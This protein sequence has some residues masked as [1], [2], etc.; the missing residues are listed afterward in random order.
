M[1]A[2]SKGES[3]KKVTLFSVDQ[4]VIEATARGVKKQGAKLTA[5]TFMFAFVDLVLAEKNGFYTVTAADIIEPFEEISM[6]ID[7]FELASSAL[8]IVKEI[9]RGNINNSEIF[10]ELLNFFRLICFEDVSLKFVWCKWVLDML[11][12]S[13]YKLDLSRCGVCNKKAEVSNSLFID[14]QTGSVYCDVHKPNNA[15]MRDITSAEH[16][17]IS[18]LY[19]VNIVDLVGRKIKDEN[20]K[21]DQIFD[22]VRALVEGILGKKLKSILE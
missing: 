10:I 20:I 13:G 17:I 5:C 11:A 12:L 4:G 14:V 3:D 9:T 19:H 15:I 21:D 2:V 18:A 1:N 6:D 8:E 22:F 16:K 7:K